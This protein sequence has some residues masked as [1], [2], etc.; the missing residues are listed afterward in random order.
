MQPIS[1]QAPEYHHERKTADWYWAVGI[2][3]VSIGAVSVF[4]GNTIF[5]ILIIVGAFSLML[6]A[7]R[8]PE[9]IR[10]TLDERGVTAGKLRYP[11]SSLK[12]F[13]IN[14]HHKPA[15]LLIT[16]KKTLAPQ[17]VVSLQDVPVE[18]V[19]NFLSER[20]DEEEQHEP[21]IQLVMEYLGF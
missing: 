13:W 9:T 11:Y 3:A 14:E 12:S 18:D 5:A 15:K 8:P 2:I 4:L 6:Y 20:L 7:T 21:I 17:I 16:A 1:W 19:H 10:V